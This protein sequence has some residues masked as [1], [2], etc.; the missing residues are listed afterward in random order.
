MHKL[1]LGDLKNFQVHEKKLV[2]PNSQ[3]IVSQII[4]GETMEIFV[5][6]KNPAEIISLSKNKTSLDYSERNSF[7]CNGNEDVIIS[8]IFKN[9]SKNLSEIVTR[10]R[11]FD[12]LL[13]SR[14]DLKKLIELKSESERFGDTLKY[15]WGYDRDEKEQAERKRRKPRK[16]ID[17]LKEENK[18]FK[19]GNFVKIE[20]KLSK[21]KI[22]E[23]TFDK[24]IGRGDG[25]LKLISL[26]D[27]F[28]DINK[29]I[30]YLKKVANPVIQDLAIKLENEYRQINFLSVSY[31][32]GLYLD[33]K[34]K[35]INKFFTQADNIFKILNQV[36]ALLSIA[37]KIKED[38][39]SKVSF[40]ETKSMEFKK[41]W[42]FERTKKG[43]DRGDK[44]PPQKLNDSMDNTPCNVL[45]GDIMSGKSFQGELNKQLHICAQSIGYAPAKE[46]N[47]HIFD[48]FV[49]IDRA[50]TDSGKGLSAFGEDITN[51]NKL[52]ELDSKGGK[53]FLFMDEWGS[54][55]SPEDQATL[56]KAIL[57]H[58]A[59]KG[60]KVVLATHNEEFVKY[61]KDN[62]NFSVYHLED[63]LNDDGTITFLYELKK[64]IGEHHIL[65]AAKTLGLPESIH[66]TAEQ[67]LEGNILEANIPEINFRNVMRY[68]P[69]ER[70]KLKQELGSFMSLM[71]HKDEIKII[72]KKEKRYD[73]FAHDYIEKQKIVLK[74]RYSLDEYDRE[75]KS[76]SSWGGGREYTGY[77]P[78]EKPE[79][80]KIL[81]VIS[82]DDD[83]KRTHF[84]GLK[85]QRY[86]DIGKFITQSP[87]R[88]SQDIFEIQKMLEEIERLGV[89]KLEEERIKLHNFLWHLNRSLYTIRDYG[90]NFNN[91]LF[92]DT[93]KEF[94]KDSFSGRNFV[95]AFRLFTLSIKISLELSGLKIEDDS[96]F[97]E[98]LAKFDLLFEFKQKIKE[99]KKERDQEKKDGLYE[100]LNE[101]EF[102]MK[103]IENGKEYNKII[104]DCAKLAGF[105]T[106]KKDWFEISQIITFGCK[107]IGEEL[108]EYYK[109]KFKSYNL[110]DVDLQ[111]VKKLMNEEKGALTGYDWMGNSDISFICGL[112][113]IVGQY[114]NIYSLTNE[115]KKYDCVY[116]HQISNYWE[117]ILK[118]VLGDIKTGDDVFQILKV[119]YNSNKDEPERRTKIKS[120]P[121]FEKFIQDMFN[122]LAI[123]DLSQMIKDNNFCKVNFNQTGSIVLDEP[124]NPNKKEEEQVKNKFYFGEDQRVVIKTGANMS[125]KTQS[126][127]HT[128]WPLAFANA[129]GYAPAKAMNTPL[130]D[131]IYWVDRIKARQD[132][133][134]S[135]GG[136]EVIVLKQI[137][138]E[139]SK[140]KG[141][142]IGFFDEMWS[143]V[144]PRFQTALT[145]ATIREFMQKGVYID[146]SHHNHDFINKLMQNHPEITESVHFKTNIM[147][148]GTVSF[149]YKQE[150]G[151]TQSQALL[152]AKTC[153]L[154]QEILDIADRISKDAN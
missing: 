16:R 31:F 44:V 37:Y 110:F 56:L 107:Q 57:T 69:E 88:S 70:E 94:K 14:V 81:S 19:V 17:I 137:F 41:A 93:Y 4:E 35:E 135:S 6:P 8:N 85:M 147:D 66:H 39:Y 7:R 108:Y 80:N 133:N 144:P 77:Q 12:E 87:V 24:F 20:E 45:V 68:T 92:E 117:N 141:M 1:R 98:Q 27:E 109:D 71:P 115:L 139:I 113:A 121:D 40:D 59:Q 82:D 49:S 32:V 52:L 51:I 15:L 114:V 54:T 146:I 91:H 103:Q 128:I 125:G 5:N 122:L 65:E 101:E 152:V 112:Y 26:K 89:E 106:S 79:Y 58:M 9:P 104:D 150:R 43:R 86:E 123:F 134:L 84:E 142:N 33:G 47:V 36:G 18:E 42:Q 105:D 30:V 118:E 48:R 34:E 136:T 23:K 74:W 38:E 2:L 60:I 76:R 127:K 50:L 46:V 3:E 99:W 21:G 61:V 96:Y 140:S 83:F 129:I 62:V 131:K 154:T 116:F 13:S 126:L 72:Y 95:H 102:K 138:E 111:I 63:K 119:S 22:D 132:L 73:S 25:M 11:V 100:K 130:I 151:H 55:T 78:E 28:N 53:T 143:T 145:Y 64:G 149:D 148:D 10:Q 29:L 67:Y 153:G 75:E 124:Y 120:F 97:K 90:E